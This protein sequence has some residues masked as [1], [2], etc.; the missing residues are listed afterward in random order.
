MLPLLSPREWPARMW[1]LLSLLDDS[2]VTLEDD[3]APSGEARPFRTVI[4]FFGA[5]LG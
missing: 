2:D 3:E 5:Y 4:G 1:N